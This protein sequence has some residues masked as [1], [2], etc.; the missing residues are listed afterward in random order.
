VFLEVIDDEDTLYGLLRLRIPSEKAHRPEIRKGRAALVRELHVYG[1]QL[2]V[3]KHAEDLIWWQHRGIGKALLAEAE[4][5]ALEEF[6]CYR[7]FVIA[8]VG[9]RDYYRALGYRK[10]PGSF[11]MFKNLKRGILKYSI[12]DVN[13]ELEELIAKAEA[14]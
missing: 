12:D 1:P 3:G 11:Y 13:R 14:S 9:V 10:Y 8:A 2:P 6:G 5:I 7:M 4:R